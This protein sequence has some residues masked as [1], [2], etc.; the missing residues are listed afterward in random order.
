M[1][2]ALGKGV[3]EVCGESAPLSG[4]EQDG[5]EAEAHAEAVPRPHALPAARPHAARASENTDSTGEGP[6]FPNLV[7]E[8][9]FRPWGFQQLELVSQ[10]EE[11]R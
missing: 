2:A 4:P 5:A 9:P 8:T 7:L 11:F 1:S 3:G 10:E 6:C